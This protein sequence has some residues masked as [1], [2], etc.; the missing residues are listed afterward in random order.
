M[1]IPERHD[2]DKWQKK[3]D[4][5]LAKWKSR[6]GKVDKDTKGNEEKSTNPSQPNKLS[7]SKSLTVAL[8]TKLGVSDGDTAKIIEDAMK[9]AGKA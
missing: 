4:E 8:T 9:E 3:K 1:Y 5:H 2:H 6:H 7:L